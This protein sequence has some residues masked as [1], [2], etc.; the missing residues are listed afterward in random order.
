[1]RDMFLEWKF[2]LNTGP[3]CDLNQ[4]QLNTM[5]AVRSHSIDAINRASD[6]D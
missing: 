5:G 1:M 6:T 3:G 2:W 4:N